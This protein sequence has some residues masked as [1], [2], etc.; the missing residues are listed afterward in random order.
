MA[1]NITVN[2]N[3]APGPTAFEVTINPQ[4]KSA[5]RNGNGML[6][7][8]TLPDKW[9]ISCEWEFGTP[10][11]FYAWFNI[12]KGLTRVNFPILFPAPTG[13]IETATFYISP[14]SAKMINF[15]RGASGWWKTL[16]TSFVEV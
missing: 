6:V 1:I 10:E 12:L 8:E 15:S 2:G 4:Q 13:N 7:R 14:I 11:E 5:E 9:S 3:T 16:K